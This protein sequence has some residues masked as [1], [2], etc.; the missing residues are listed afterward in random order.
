MVKVIFGSVKKMLE[1]YLEDT[2]FWNSLA[3]INTYRKVV[4]DASPHYDHN[5]PPTFSV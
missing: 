3:M 4:L 5:W 2:P 1:I